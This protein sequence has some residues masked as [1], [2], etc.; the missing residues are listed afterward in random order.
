MNELAL[1][2]MLLVGCAVIGVGSSLVFKMK[3]DNKAEQAAEQVIKKYSGIDIDL[4]P[5]YKERKK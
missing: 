5:E 4:S 3:K 1:K 2:I